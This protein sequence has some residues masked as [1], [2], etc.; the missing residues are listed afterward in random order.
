[1]QREAL[2][3]QALD[4]AARALVADD[5]QRHA[6]IHLDSFSTAW[7]TCWPSSEHY[8]S[9]A[10]FGEVATRYLGL[11]SPAREC[12]SG[13]PIAGSRTT[14]DRF[15]FRLSALPLQGDG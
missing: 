13:S 2:R 1:M 4:V 11:P 14:L 6:W 12:F 9:N 3:F 8:M 7:V 5:V 15:G 10:E